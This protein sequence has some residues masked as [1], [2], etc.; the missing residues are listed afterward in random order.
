MIQKIAYIWYPV[1][2]MNRAIEFYNELLG[3]TLLFKGEDWSELEIDGQRLAF[4]GRV[5]MDL[6]GLDVT[7]CP[8]AAPGAMVEILGPHQSIDD[9]AA[10]AGTIGHEILTSLGSR[11]RRR[12]TGA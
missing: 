9:L 1:T 7:G 3:L 12:Y 8:A 2:D 4:A 6:I 10:A 11:Y 5:S